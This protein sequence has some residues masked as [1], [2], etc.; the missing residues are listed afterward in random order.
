MGGHDKRAEGV[1]K[2]KISNELVGGKRKKLKEVKA[3][4]SL[5]FFTTIFS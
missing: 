2:S 5:F 3:H 1:V 4:I